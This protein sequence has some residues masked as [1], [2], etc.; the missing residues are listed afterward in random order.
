MQKQQEYSYE[1]N[2]KALGTGFMWLTIFQIAVVISSAAYT[3]WN[4][5]TFFVKKAIY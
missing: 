4:L 3:V 2:Q 5:K 1:S